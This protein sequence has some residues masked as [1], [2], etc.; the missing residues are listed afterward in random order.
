MLQRQQSLTRSGNCTLYTRDNDDHNH[1]LINGCYFGGRGISPHEAAL[2]TRRRRVLADSQCR[3]SSTESCVKPM[4]DLA[5][6]LRELLARTRRAGPADLFHVGSGAH[7]AVQWPSILIWRALLSCRSAQASRS[8]VLGNGAPLLAV[9]LMRRK[10]LSCALV[11][12]VCNAATPS[13]HPAR[14]LSSAPLPPLARLARR[15]CTSQQSWPLLGCVV[16]HDAA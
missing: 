8:R 16:L 6:H 9:R 3:C 12:P 1:D 7:A 14:V 11:V 10:Q 15:L 2:Q 5:V 13:G 4:V